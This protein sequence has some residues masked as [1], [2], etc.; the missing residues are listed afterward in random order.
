MDKEPERKKV[1]SKKE[2]FLKACNYCAYQERSQNE[3]RSKLY[4]L[5][6]YP[7]DVELVISD[8]IQEN[9][10]NEERFANAYTSG[11]FRIKGWGKKKI[12]QGLLLKRVPEKIIAN[13]LKKVDET[14][15]LEKLSQ[16]LLKKKDLLKEKNQLKERY[17]LTQYALLKGYESDLIS[18]V[19]NNNKLT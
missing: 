12:K 15:Y 7:S 9:F 14:Q 11:K 17:K 4:D 10:I 13:A 1:Y 3:V 5:G 8:L 18:D 19:L 2:G 16:L 6:L